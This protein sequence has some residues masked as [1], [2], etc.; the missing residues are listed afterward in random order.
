VR[1]QENIL[2]GGLRPLGGDFGPSQVR[3]CP[4]LSANRKL[5][6]APICPAEVSGATFCFQDWLLSSSY[7]K[8]R[9]RCGAFREP[10]R[11]R[12]VALTVTT[13]S[14]E[15]SVSIKPIGFP[16]LSLL[17]IMAFLL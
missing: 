3:V 13:R 8:S 16:L 6:S 4:G 14:F 9:A 11:T 1:S 17:M 7:V 12:R 5:P 2:K 10:Y 15:I